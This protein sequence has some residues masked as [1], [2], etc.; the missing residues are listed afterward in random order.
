M[1]GFRKQKMAWKGGSWGQHVPVLPSNVAPPSDFFFF[2]KHL[3]QFEYI[4]DHEL[5][6]QVT[7]AVCE[8][9][10]LHV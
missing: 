1:M 8:S 5:Q 7:S 2:L 6:A 3:Y 10:D 4:R 9:P